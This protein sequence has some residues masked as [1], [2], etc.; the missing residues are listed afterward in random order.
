M[1]KRRPFV[2]VGAIA[3]AISQIWMGMSAEIAS[4]FYPRGSDSYYT[5]AQI[6]AIFGVIFCNT[7]INVELA[8]FRS[9]IADCV[10]PEAQNKGAT[11]SG[12][13]MGGSF[14]LCDI[15]ML[16]MYEM[17]NNIKYTEIYPLLSVIA[18]LTTVSLVIP[19]V[20]VAVETPLKIK[21]KDNANAFKQLFNEFKHMDKIFYVA[22]LPLLF[23]WVGYTPIQQFTG[24]VFDMETTFISQIC[25]NGVTTLISPVFGPI[26]EKLGEKWSFFICGCTNIIST[27][28]LVL[29]GYMQD[30]LFNE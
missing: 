9:L 28:M 14:M 15:I 8:S 7:F 27:V 11:Y 22:M 12:F 16:I 5:F 4:L 3:T 30:T 18:A 10:P 25:L 13:M 2:I 23:G 17:D 29:S 24:T 1:G 26:I 20:F 21:T 19:T 6:W